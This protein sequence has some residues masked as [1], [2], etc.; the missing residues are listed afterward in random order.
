MNEYNVMIKY[1]NRAHT[2]LIIHLESK[3]SNRTI[4]RTV[5]IIEVQ[6]IEVLLCLSLSIP[7]KDNDLLE[8]L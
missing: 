5:R 8:V 3:Y 6:I 7:S 2:I 1:S 4:S